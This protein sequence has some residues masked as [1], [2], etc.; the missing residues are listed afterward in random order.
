MLVFAGLLIL[1]APVA[2]A[3]AFAT[4]S[5]VV[6]VGKVDGTFIA[7]IFYSSLDSFPLIAI[8][9]F[10]YAGDLMLEG[11]ISRRLINFA[12]ALIGH[13]RGHLGH[14]TVIACAFF[15]AI[16][17]SGV[18]TVAAVGSIMIPEM[19]NDRYPRGYAGALTATAA[20][21]GFIIP[22]SIPMI[23]YGFIANTSVADLFIA[24]LIP[25]IILAVVF[26]LLNWFY[27]SR[28]KLASS[29]GVH[30]M[31]AA[32]QED[33]QASRFRAIL[34][35]G[36]EAIFAIL[37]PVLI[38]GGIYGG[39]FT[40]TEAS[41]MAVLYAIFVGFL[42]YRGLNWRRFVEV[43]KNSTI[44]SAMIMIILV[45][46]T[47][48]SRIITREKVPQTIADYILSS[49]ASETVVLLLML[50]FL[51]LIGMLV[52]AITGVILVTPL[53]YNIAV[54]GMGM[55]PTHLGTIIVVAL[56]IGLITPPMAVNLFLASQ[57]SGSTFREILLYLWPFLVAST[58]TLLLITFVP[59][60]SLFLVE[61]ISG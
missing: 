15:A 4:F 44:T 14:I 2:F 36:K 34:A 11:G 55:D 33:G 17:G 52:D 56:S 12:N 5:Y 46:A 10:I 58:V 57:L 50:A 22:P 51:I 6:F 60:I 40:P 20:M 37:M 42:I 53:L 49:A 48:F 29:E 16:S 8:P 26:L 9:F 38:L 45:F 1:G 30:S 25:G 18:A 7:P 39:Y 24:G 19:I 31:T 61:M 41:V 59:G 54:T 43:T 23:M 47:I 27:T 28:F 3:F 13:I 35:T 21:L 32:T